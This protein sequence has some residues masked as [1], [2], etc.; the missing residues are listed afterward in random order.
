LNQIDSN[1]QRRG[2]QTKHTRNNSAMVAGKDAVKVTKKAL[3]N[4]KKRAAMSANMEKEKTKAEKAATTLQNNAEKIATKYKSVNEENQNLLAEIEKLK[5]QVQAALGKFL[6][7][8]LLFV[9]Q[10]SSNTFVNF[11]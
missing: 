1:S 3:D 6:R 4:L 10:E 8:R 5:A 9:L 2:A 7:R 11:S